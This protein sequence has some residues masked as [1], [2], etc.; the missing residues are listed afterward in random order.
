[1]ASTKTPAKPAKTA[2]V[3]PKKGDRA[4]LMAVKRQLQRTRPKFTRH[5]PDRK[6]S[7]D[8]RWKKPRGLHNK[9]K[10]RKRGCAPWVSDGYR[11]PV[12]VR[13][14]HIS[15]LAIVRVANVKELAAVDAQ[16][17]GVVIAAVGAKRQLEILR[18]CAQKNIRVLNH[19]SNDRIATIESRFAKAKEER[20]VAREESKKKAAEKEKAAAKT[21]EEPAQSEEEKRD[22]QEEIKKEVLTG[23]EQ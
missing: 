20:Q 22:E 18:A 4:N 14:L 1:M 2:K 13:G 19:K 6:S 12:E 5:R 11:T 17:S 23:K 10:D 9:L 15:G 16:T 7:L 21:K 3:A 8:D